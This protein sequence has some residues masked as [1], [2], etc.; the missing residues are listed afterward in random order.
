M[1]ENMLYEDVYIEPVNCYEGEF[2]CT[3]TGMEC[4]KCGENLDFLDWLHDFREKGHHDHIE[5]YYCGEVDS[6]ICD[7]INESYC[8]H[9]SQPELDC[10]CPSYEDCG[11]IVYECGCEPIEYTEEDIYP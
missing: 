2:Y 11:Q 3:E 4:E 8:Q 9:C 5:C 1:N 6:C 10:D 7:E